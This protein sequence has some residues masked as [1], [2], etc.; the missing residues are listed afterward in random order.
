[1]PEAYPERDDSSSHGGQVIRVGTA[2]SLDGSVKAQ[3]FERAGDSVCH[4]YGEGVAGKVRGISVAQKKLGWTS[5][6]SAVV[7]IVAVSFGY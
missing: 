6:V 1:M 5:V 3:A 4:I 2:D 7:G